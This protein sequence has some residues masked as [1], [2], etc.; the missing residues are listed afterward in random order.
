[1]LVPNTI[2]RAAAKRRSQIPP[3]SAPPETADEHRHRTH[4][5]TV[6]MP[7]RAEYSDP[8]GCRGVRIDEL[9]VLAEKFREGR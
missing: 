3:T 5:R 9:Q 8:L 4:H 6:S 7:A 2:T 1:M